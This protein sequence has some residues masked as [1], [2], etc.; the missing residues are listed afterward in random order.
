[1]IKKEKTQPNISRSEIAKLERNLFVGNFFKARKEARQILDTSE[2]PATT[3]QRA[4]IALKITWPD[5]IALLIGV[6]CLAFSI[7]VLF[8]ARY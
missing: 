4:A 5:A 3:Y 8:L 7:T 2:L 6:L 1:M